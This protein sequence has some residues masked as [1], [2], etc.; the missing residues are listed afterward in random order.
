MMPQGRQ[1]DALIQLEQAIK[2]ILD[3]SSIGPSEFGSIHLDDSL[4][5]S[6]RADILEAQRAVDDSQ[7]LVANPDLLR[8][9]LN[10]VLYSM[11]SDSDDRS[12]FGVSVEKV[13]AFYT[14][15]RRE[16]LR[17]S[18]LPEPHD[19][20]ELDEERIHVDI[21]AAVVTVDGKPYGLNGTDTV[22]N[23]L[24]EFIDLLIAEDGEYVSRPQNI[25]TRHI[26]QQPKAVRDLIESQP[27]AGSPYSATQEVAQLSHFLAFDKAILGV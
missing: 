21:E 12:Y 11:G 14:D 24:A 4:A 6:L 9:T 10:S 17:R 25:K 2:R 16:I 5:N 7:A 27:G 3:N 18:D 26:E 15:V 23:R 19:D 22:K 13:K 20:A 1:V 8:F